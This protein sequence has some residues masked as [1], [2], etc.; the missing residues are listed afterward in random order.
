MGTKRHSWPTTEPFT[1]HQKGM[2]MTPSAKL[3]YCLATAAACALSSLL[4]AA[5][6]RKPVYQ[7]FAVPD[8]IATYPLSINAQRTIT[9]YYV[10]TDGVTHGFVRDEDGVI[11]KFD[12]PGSTSTR[13]DSIN[14]AG[15]ITGTYITGPTDPIAGIPQGFVR[16]AEGKITLFGNTVNLGGSNRSFN[17][18][19][20]QVNVD[21]EVAG[22]LPYPLAAPGVFVRSRKGVVQV[23]SLSIGASYPTVATGLNAGGAVVGYTSSDDRHFQGFLWSGQGP[24]P[25]PFSGNLTSISVSGSTATFPTALN[26][27]GTVVGCYSIANPVLPNS[28]TYYDFLYESDGTITTL[29]IPGTVPYCGYSGNEET[30][31]YNVTPRTITLNG[32]GTI[33]GTYTNAAKVPVGFIQ[34]KDG[35][36]TTFTHPNATMTMPTA[37]NNQDVIIGYFAK[38]T[39]IKGFLRLP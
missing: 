36:L 26:A 11:T 32:E 3:R 13:P 30:G 7:E 38:G 17:A 23:F 34:K 15:E 29:A 25:S 6:N 24:V 27:E 35:K 33:V 28:L 19:P 1:K 22:N 9:G 4:S 10:T 16:S 21:G 20:A 14:R 12:V 31:V 39:N 8:S 37:I 18:N 2:L 5:E